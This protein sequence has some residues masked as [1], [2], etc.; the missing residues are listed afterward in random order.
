MISVA[1]SLALSSFC[2]SFLQCVLQNVH[3]ISISVLSVVSADIEILPFSY[4][5]SPFR[6][7]KLT[8]LTILIFKSFSKKHP[9]S[10]HSSLLYGYGGCYLTSAC[11]IAFCYL[12]YIFELKH[13]GN[14][15]VLKELRALPSSLL[16]T[17]PASVTQAA[18]IN[19][20]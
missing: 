12:K 19:G 16:T 14:L 7:I 3:S 15:V 2:I 9:P 17:L 8:F 20:K 1:F 6:K 10:G 4:S 11:N 18:Y 5:P 13:A